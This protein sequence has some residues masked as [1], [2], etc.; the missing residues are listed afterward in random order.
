[1]RSSF[2]HDLCPFIPYYYSLLLFPII[3]PSHSVDYFLLFPSLLLSFLSFP[4]FPFFFFLAFFTCFFLCCFFLSRPSFLLFLSYSVLSPSLPQ[5]NS[6]TLLL[7]RKQRST[8]SRC[9]S[10]WPSSVTCPG[11]VKSMNSSP[12]SSTGTSVFPTRVVV[13]DKTHTN[14]IPTT[15]Q[16]HTDPYQQHTNHISLTYH[17]PLLTTYRPDHL[18]HC[19]PLGC[20]LKVGA[21]H[22]AKGW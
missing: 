14:H 17:L 16:P 5:L 18:V 4:L 9:Y 20:R 6:A 11:T 19:N 13:G 7:T 22:R 12:W 10:T 15:Y 1:M 21:G 8:L 2:S 3:I